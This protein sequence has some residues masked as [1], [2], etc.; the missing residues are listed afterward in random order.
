MSVSTY[1]YEC[2]PDCMHFLTDL[3]R[4]R[5]MEDRYAPQSA[6]T[7][8]VS[9]DWRRRHCCGTSGVREIRLRRSKRW[10][11][12]SGRFLSSSLLVFP[13]TFLCAHAFAF[14]SSSCS[15]H[16]PNGTGQK[17]LSAGRRIQ[18]GPFRHPVCIGGS[19]LCSCGIMPS[20]SAQGHIHR[21]APAFPSDSMHVEALLQSLGSN[22]RN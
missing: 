20:P 3:L 10:P 14:S 8:E 18:S 21:P 6:G 12:F 9:A 16:F 17:L 13:F 11:I 4:K 1:G 15:R 5:L 7:A 2:F 19:R 22:K